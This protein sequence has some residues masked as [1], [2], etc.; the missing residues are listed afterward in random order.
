MKWHTYA[1]DLLSFQTQI[2]GLQ[3]KAD[4]MAGLCAC[5]GF[6]VSS[7]HSYS[8][9]VRILSKSTSKYE[10]V[11]GRRHTGH[12]K[13]LGV[14]WDTDIR[15]PTHREIIRQTV[16][17]G[18]NHIV[19]RRASME[20]KILAMQRSLFA[21]V[22]YPAKFMA[23]TCAEYEV[24]DRVISAALR[25][26]TRNMQTFPEALLYAG[27]QDGGFGFTKW[28]DSIQLMKNRII[29]YGQHGA[30]GHHVQAMVRGSS[31]QRG[32]HSSHGQGRP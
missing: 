8:H 5:L 10:T 3:A 25:K 24:I 1:D 6:Q 11:N 18:C 28:S 15:N 17:E 20:S 2:E 31:R 29:Q 27:K 12:L 26:I 13:H 16:T 32:P 23:W 19:A 30:A 21:K 7:G 14:I 4:M 9:G 22:A